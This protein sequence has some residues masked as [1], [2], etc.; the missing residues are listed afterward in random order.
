MNLDFI[1]AHS[2]AF[3]VEGMVQRFLGKLAKA[4]ERCR[5][6]FQ[7][8]GGLSTCG[9]VPPH[10][11][12]LPPGEGTAGVRRSAGVCAVGGWRFFPIP[13][14][15]SAHPLPAGEG[16]GEGE[17][18]LQRKR[19]AGPQAVLEGAEALNIEHSTPNNQASMMHAS[20]LIEC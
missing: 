3:V 19:A 12:P 14:R 8:D 16:R 20:R 13:A 6:R 11:D 7:A 9:A 15:A 10:P 17:W 5:G 4:G 18:P 2:C 1:G